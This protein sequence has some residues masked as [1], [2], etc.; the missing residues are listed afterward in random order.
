LEKIALRGCR[1]EK[2]IYWTK[3]AL[4]RQKE[5]EEKAG[6]TR[7]EVEDLLLHPEQLVPGDGEVMVAQR[8][9]AGGLLRVAFLDEGERLKI[10]TLYWTRRVERY[11]RD[12]D[13][14]SL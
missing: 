2:S 12:E 1:V 3:H 4:F 7:E 11:W 13:A 6:I 14:H 8:K 9:R 10:I 5:W